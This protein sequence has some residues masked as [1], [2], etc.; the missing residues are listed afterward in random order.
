MRQLRLVFLIGLAAFGAFLVGSMSQGIYCHVTTVDFIL[1]DI[2]YGNNAGDCAAGGSA[3]G[4]MLLVPSILFIHLPIL[5][6]LRSVFE[7]VRPAILFVLLPAVPYA[8]L[9][10]LLLGWDFLPVLGVSSLMFG[11]GSQMVMAAH[12]RQSAKL[13]EENL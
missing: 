12:D 8:L 9:V 7:G 5:F 2:N 3:W 6:V 4:L 1:H 13:D 10:W 11:L